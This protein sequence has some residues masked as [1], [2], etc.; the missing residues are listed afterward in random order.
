MHYF[1][2]ELVKND[3]IYIEFCKS[4]HK[5]ID[6]FKKPHW[7]FRT[8]NIGGVYVESLCGCN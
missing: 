4:K 5:L 7:Q 3:E 6:I 2:R 8:H 1:I